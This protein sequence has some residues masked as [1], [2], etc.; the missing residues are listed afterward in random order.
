VAEIAALDAP[1]VLRGHFDANGLLISSDVPTPPMPKGE[2]DLQKGHKPG[3]L[4]RILPGLSPRSL[5]AGLKLDAEG[6]VVAVS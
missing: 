4:G 6:F 2:G 5:P 3:T 1:N